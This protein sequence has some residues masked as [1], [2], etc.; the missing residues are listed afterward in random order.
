MQ[1]GFSVGASKWSRRDVQSSEVRPTFMLRRVHQKISTPLIGLLLAL[2]ALH[3]CG[4]EAAP[5]GDSS[6]TNAVSDR[7]PLEV[8]NE[9]MSAYNR[10]DLDAF[11]ATYADG[12]AVFTYPNRSLGKGK[13]HMR[14]IFEPMFKKGAAQVVI[15]HQVVKDSFV[16]NHETVKDGD[17]ETDSVYSSPFWVVLD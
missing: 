11:L 16:V 15:H 12:V 8:V 10:H 5:S 7:S 1:T 9:R 13:A 3:G 6:G 14:S 17:T 4:G 2:G